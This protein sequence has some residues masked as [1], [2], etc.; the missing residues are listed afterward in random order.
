[1]ELNTGKYR[2][3]DLSKNFCARSVTQPKQH[4]R[5]GE[6]AVKTTPCSYENDDL[7][8]V[9][10]ENRMKN[11]IPLWLSSLMLAGCTLALAQGTK[12]SQNTQKPAASTASTA[13]RDKNVE[14]YIELLRSNV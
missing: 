4:I 10:K 6:R 14:A 12:Q 13:S 9:K 5:D 2:E 7:E 3:P 8:V 11:L 1:L